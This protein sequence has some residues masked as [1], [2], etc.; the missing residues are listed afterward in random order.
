MRE[1]ATTRKLI[2]VV[3]EGGGMR[4]AYTG[5]ALSALALKFKC[6]SPDII[7]ASSGSAAMALYYLTG[8]YDAIKAICVRL[9]STRKFISLLRFWRIVDIDYLVDH[10]FKK[11]VPLDTRCLRKS[12][13][14]YFISLTDAKTGNIHYA[15]REDGIDPFELLRATKAMPLLFGKR[16]SIN[17][18]AYID[19][20]FL[21]TLGEM[22]TKAEEAGATDIIVID[23]SPGPTIY[24]LFKWFFRKIYFPRL[25][26]KKERGANIGPR[27]IV[28]KN[29]T[30]PAG[31]LTTKNE[32]LEKTF[33]LGYDDAVRSR[34]LE[35]LFREKS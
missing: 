1:M 7:I 22:V 5:G 28:I 34:E 6:T 20:E 19:G 15:C 3:C 32:T 4:C 29:K 17:G 12:N 8:Q 33:W 9:L 24:D 13:T 2:A 11:D 10:V 26:S 23:N 27:I 14:H 25:G 18:T 31:L 30:I 21:G 35:D 16:V